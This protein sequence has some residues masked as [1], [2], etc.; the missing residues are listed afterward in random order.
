MWKSICIGV[1]SIFFI[2]GSLVACDDSAE[3]PESAMEAEAKAPTPGEVAAKESPAP[4]PLSASGKFQEAVA[5]AAQEK[6]KEAIDAFNEV[7]VGWP[8]SPEAR[9]MP[10]KRHETFLAHSRSIL[11]SGN[12]LDTAGSLEHYMT[13]EGIESDFGKRIGIIR[14]F[15]GG[16]ENLMVAWPLA[17][18][19]RGLKSGELT[20]LM[21]LDRHL[22]VIGDLQITK[23]VVDFYGKL[24]CSE[25]AKN[26]EWAACLQ[27]SPDPKASPLSELKTYLEKVGQSC[28][29]MS[30]VK[31]LCGEQVVA[32]AMQAFVA[33]QA[34][35]ESWVQRSRSEAD[36]AKKTLVKLG[37][38]IKKMVKQHQKATDKYTHALAFGSPAQ[39]RRALSKAITIGERW[40]KKTEKVRE[41]C[42]AAGEVASA[43]WPADLA[44]EIDS[45]VYENCN[46]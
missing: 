35:Q 39:Q 1:L 34:V 3:S 36:K 4:T 16:D 9:L 2:G 32:P 13:V 24:I 23:P 26:P 15:T 21:M 22:K 8:D 46:D 11:A 7:Q 37:K 40:E 28:A 5:L 14:N 12:V 38:K 29:S 31:G 33:V 27:P 42:R 17:P 19:G 6:F 20:P 10:K 18:L 30:S 44:K 25:V 43:A 41:K 45:L